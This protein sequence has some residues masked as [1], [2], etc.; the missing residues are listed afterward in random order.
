MI[1]GALPNLALDYPVNKINVNL[2]VTFLFFIYFINIL[3]FSYDQGLSLT[4]LLPLKSGTSLRS[5]SRQKKTR[6]LVGVAFCTNRQ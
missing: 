5:F 6:A 4:L 3:T 1:E 2:L